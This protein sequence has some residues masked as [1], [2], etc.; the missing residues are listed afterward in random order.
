VG[1]DSRVS[2][3]D[4]VE[5]FPPERWKS[6]F[7]EEMVRLRPATAARLADQVSQQ[8]YEKH[9]SMDPKDAADLWV[10]DSPIG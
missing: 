8:A 1:Y 2:P 9:A 7:V 5:P 10:R 6:A 3:L 4:H